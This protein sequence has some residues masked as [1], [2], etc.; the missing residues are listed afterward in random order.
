MPQSEAATNTH[1]LGSSEQMYENRHRIS[2]QYMREFTLGK[3]IVKQKDIM[4]LD[5]IGE[6]ITHES[7]TE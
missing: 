4:L 3:F 5:S 7:L 2:S 6:G 1:A